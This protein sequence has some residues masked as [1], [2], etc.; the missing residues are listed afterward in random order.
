MINGPAV[1]MLDE[2]AAKIPAGPGL[3]NAAIAPKSNITAP[4]TYKIPAT[5]NPGTDLAI[6]RHAATDPGRPN[7][8]NPDR[9]EDRARA[10]ARASTK[11]RG[12]RRTTAADRG[13]TIRS[14]DTRKR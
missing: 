12:N 10:S 8:Q 5:T 13:R 3:A 11:D 6:S 2:M 1:M 4:S 14:T 7:H 9:S